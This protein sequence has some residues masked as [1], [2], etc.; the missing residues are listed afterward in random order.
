MAGGL[1]KIFPDLVLSRMGKHLR[2][3]KVFVDWSQNDAKKTTVTAYSLRAKD[4]PTV[5]TPVSWAEVTKAA[6]TGEILRFESTATLRRIKAR[7][8]LFAPVLSM[9]QELPP[10]R[11]LNSL[12]GMRLSRESAF[13]SKHRL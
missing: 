8:D 4:H 6:K 9:R 5:S 7:G 10:L 11:K 3:G 12:L 2:S 1:E 13:F